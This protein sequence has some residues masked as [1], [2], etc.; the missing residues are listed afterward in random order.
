MEENNALQRILENEKIRNEIDFVIRQIDR[1]EFKSYSISNTANKFK[2]DLD[3][4]IAKLLS[5]HKYSLK[6]GK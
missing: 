6:N 1:S 2:L 3:S 5:I 4:P